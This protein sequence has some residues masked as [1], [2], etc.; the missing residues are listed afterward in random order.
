MMEKYLNAALS[1]EERAEDL[2]GK[3]SLEEKMGQVNCVFP[4]SG[5]MD[6]AKKTIQKSHGI[7]QISTLDMRMS[8]SLEEA[9]AWQRDLQKTAMEASE[10]HIPAVFHMEGL[11]GA[12]IPDA[13]SFPS[14]IA[15]G[16]SW[17]PELERKIAE[18]VGKEETACGVTQTFAPVLDISRD[19]RMGRQGET[20][21]E[22][23]ALASAMGAAYTKGVQEVSEGGRK[24]DATAKHFVGFHDS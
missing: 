16:S 12:F 22:D 18:V 19:S 23:P 11:S 17:N 3:M 7:G 13:V 24:T 10:H 21:G 15:R 4:F 8:N 1:P 20:Y 14:G 9:A 2:L 5:M 6:L